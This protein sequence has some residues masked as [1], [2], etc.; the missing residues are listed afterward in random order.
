MDDQITTLLDN[1]DLGMRLEFIERVGTLLYLLGESEI[2]ITLHREYAALGWQ[3]RHNAEKIRA[4][5]EG[6]IRDRGD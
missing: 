6:I 2:D 5:L 1:E 4:R 3:I